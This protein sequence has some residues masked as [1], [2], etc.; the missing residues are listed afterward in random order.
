MQ[1]SAR[2][3]KAAS[4]SLVL[5]FMVILA[6]SIVRM[7][8]SGM[9]CP[10]W[11]K[12]FGHYIPPTDVE[13][14]TYAAG[15]SF[16]KGMMIIMNDQ[17]WVAQQS[18]VAGGDFDSEPWEVYSVHDY[19]LY[20]P[21]HTWVEYI[22]RLT[23]A[24]SG[25]PVLILFGLSFVGFLRRKDLLTFVLAALTLFMLGFE[26]W[27]GK[28]VVDAHLAVAKI[29]L[30]MLGSIAIVALLLMILYRHHKG[31]TEYRIHSPFWKIMSVAMMIMAITQVILGTQVREEIDVVSA[32]SSDRSTWIASLS[33]IFIIHRSFS[34]LIVVL[35]VWMFLRSKGLVKLPFSLKGI[36]WIAG[37]EIM[38][39]IVL[40]Y[41]HVPAPMQPLHLLLAIFWFACAWYF[42]LQ[43]WRPLKAF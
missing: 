41:V 17:L 16:D 6:G 34:I 39:G 33:G 12:C 38:A 3:Y 4:A 9:G 10:D 1:R 5:I 37:L 28:T 7:S 8:G 21:T 22:N 31:D 27:L 14:L 32:V 29:T 15:K 24:L 30:H 20:N 18:I 42:F 40:A 36:F 19:A 25:L 11:P 13:E 35:L 23:G 43:V 2:I 26:A